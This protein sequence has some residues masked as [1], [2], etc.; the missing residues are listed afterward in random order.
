VET[1]HPQPDPIA[2]PAELFHTFAPFVGRCL[3]YLGVSEAD[4]EDAVQEVFLVVH[5]RHADLRT[6]DGA[7][8][9]LY[10][11]AYHTAQSFRRRG[12]QR[13]A[14]EAARLDEVAEA[15]VGATETSRRIEARDAALALL[16]QLDDDKRAVFV[17]YHVEQMSMAEVS[18]VIGAP[19]QTCYSRL[20]A[21][22]RALQAARARL[23][24]EGVP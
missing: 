22:S 24:A 4:V 20:Q 3:R 7:R 14:R 11:I 17:L 23:D 5:R 13:R 18:A 2:S 8:P 12:G 15:G 19:L 16:A 6:A 21:A 10:R 1:P 9:W